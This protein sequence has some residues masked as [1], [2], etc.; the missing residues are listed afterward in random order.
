VLSLKNMVDM[1]VIVKRAEY[2]QQLK[3]RKDK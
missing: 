3:A 2:R 1:V